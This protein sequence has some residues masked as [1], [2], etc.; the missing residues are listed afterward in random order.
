M[1]LRLAVLASGRG[2]NLQA[3]LAAIAAGTLDAE[4]VGVFGD[5][6]EAPALA[7]VALDRR[8]SARPKDF[9]DRA[10]FE[11]AL[12]DAVAAARPDWVVCAGYM[13]ILGAGIVQ[14]FGG[15]LLNIHPSLLPKYRGLHTHAQALAAS[16]AE[17][18][19]SVHFVVPELDAGAVIA[20]VRVPVQPGD[21]PDDLAQRLLPCEHRLL[22]AVLR[23][24]AA[25]RLAERDGKVWL[26][27][28]CRFSPL[29]L[30]CDDV[31]L[32]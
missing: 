1:T 28:Q 24:A 22:C 25:G 30:D 21:G 11:Q 32:P 27:G 8:W 9:P 13:R 12:G 16:D 3:I 6:P 23:L 31:L 26:D 17:H 19:A 5:R 10:A 20:Q 2:S 4:V 18:G 7:M 29:R 15:R 14:R